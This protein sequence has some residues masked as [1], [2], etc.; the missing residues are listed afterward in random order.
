MTVVWGNCLTASEALIWNWTKVQNKNDWNNLHWTCSEWG[1]TQTWSW[2]GLSKDMSAPENKVVLQRLTGLLQ[3]L[4]K[5]ILNLIQQVSDPLRK[6]E[7]NV[8]WHWGTEQQSFDKLKSSCQPSLV[9]WCKLWELRNCDT[10]GGIS[11]SVW[12]ESINWLS[13]MI[14]PNWGRIARYYIRLWEVSPISI[15][16]TCKCRKWQQQPP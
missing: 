2:K 1:R 14:R 16:K 10:S 4:S 9:C 13:K 3:Y 7:G 12:L 5:F 15:W 8:E 6:L 11:S